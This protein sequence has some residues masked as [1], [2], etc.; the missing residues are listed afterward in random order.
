MKKMKKGFTLVELLVVITIIAIL[1]AFV[2]PAIQGALFRAKLTAAAANASQMQKAIFAQETQDIYSSTRS[3]FPREDDFA[4]SS[5]YFHNL[6]TNGTLKVS[7][8]FFTAPGVPTAPDE[9]EF[10][11]GNY[12]AWC[13]VEDIVDS[14]PE[15]L[16]VIFTRN[17][18][19]Q[20]F[21]SLDN[22][23]V[24]SPNDDGISILLRE[25]ATPFGDAGFVFVTKG[26]ASYALMR[27]NLQVGTEAQPGT[28]RT[29][30]AI[31]DIDRQQYDN[32]V[33]RPA[34]EED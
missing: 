25:E 18:G 24:F 4:D 8:N 3:A 21:T 26:G 23:Q 34:Q 11:T 10:Q 17:L 2:F 27:D 30:F 12:C 33:L 31:E 16:P 15:T 13:V 28:F 22:S 6:I 14:T 1:I 9:T 5:K 19:D 7:W 20:S 32:G 29:L